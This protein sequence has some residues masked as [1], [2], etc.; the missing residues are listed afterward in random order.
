LWHNRSMPERQELLLQALLDAFQLGQDKLGEAL[1][2]F[3]GELTPALAEQTSQRYVAALQQ[4]DANGAI[5]AA[6]LASRIYNFI[7]HRED[8]FNSFLDYLNVLYQ[9]AQ[10]EDAYANVHQVLHQ[11]LERDPY[12]EGSPLTG[13]RAAVLGGDSA[14]FA[15]EA[16][17][18]DAHKQHWLQAALQ[19]L[20]SAIPLLAN[21][22]SSP[23]I[24]AFT[25]TTVA[26]YRRCVMQHWI[27][28]PWAASGLAAL[29]L[30]LDQA[31]P[32]K[33]IYPGN[34]PKTAYISA[35]RAEMSTLYSRSAYT[36]DPPSGTPISGLFGR[37]G[38]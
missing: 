8:A 25:S 20:Q 37:K 38:A 24:P 11:M 1:Q 13:L 31:V 21:P 19:D 9:L 16:A 30:A 18:E 26:V 10:T 33:V 34:D 12:G 35:A 28:E 36:G 7:G 29:T 32:Q 22:A 27:G 3:R 4:Q 2:Q 23:L 5:A 6:I 14:F 17:T 15:C